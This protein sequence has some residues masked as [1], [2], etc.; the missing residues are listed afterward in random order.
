MNSPFLYQHPD[1]GHIRY[2]ADTCTLTVSDG[3]RNVSVP[4]GP[5]G[6]IDFAAALLHAS[7][8]IVRE[9]K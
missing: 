3:E 7:R 8:D 4:I 6:M 2:D 9:G 1:G 5:L